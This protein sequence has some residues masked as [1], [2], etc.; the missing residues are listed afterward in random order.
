MY[1]W[2]L[3]SRSGNTT[4]R[5]YKDEVEGSGGFNGN[6]YFIYYDSDEGVNATYFSPLFDNGNGYGIDEPSLLCGEATAS[7][8]T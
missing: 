1:L 6:K 8:G 7:F 2:L 4:K 5:I 3:C